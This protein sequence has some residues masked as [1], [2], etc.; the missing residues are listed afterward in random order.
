MLQYTCSE[1]VDT[2][3]HRHELNVITKITK[4]PRHHE[5]GPKST[6]IRNDWCDI[7]HRWSEHTH[8]C[9]CKADKDGP[10]QKK[11]AA[12]STS[13]MRRP[14]ANLGQTTTRETLKGRGIDRTQLFEHKPKES[15][16]G[17]PL[18]VGLQI[19]YTTV[20]EGCAWHHSGAKG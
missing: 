8:R 5:D 19:I 1:M 14:K 3:V 2:H 18:G 9:R 7:I 13:M 17:E 10:T 20:H 12:T 11:H 15:S 16:N 4:V 6:L